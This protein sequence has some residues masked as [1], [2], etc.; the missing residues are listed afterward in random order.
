VIAGPT[1]VAYACMAEIILLEFQLLS[2]QEAQ[3]SQ[4][5]MPAT[6]LFYDT[7]FQLIWLA[8]PYGDNPHS[9]S[10]SDIWTSN[11]IGKGRGQQ[12][13]KCMN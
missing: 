11:S 1:T 3:H 8:N 6:I 10:A 13:K 7:M 12:T 2:Q 4:A 5:Q 9:Q